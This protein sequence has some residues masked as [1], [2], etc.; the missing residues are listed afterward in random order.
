MGV[1]GVAAAVSVWVH[2]QKGNKPA[3][4]DQSTEFRSQDDPAYA[5][6]GDEPG[7]YLEVDGTTTV[8]ATARV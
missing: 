2:K 4:F 8:A 5:G 1:V 3:R 6:P 7:G